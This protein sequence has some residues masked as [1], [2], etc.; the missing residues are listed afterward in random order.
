MKDKPVLDLIAAIKPIITEK[1][2]KFSG[3]NIVVFNVPVA[4][5]KNLMKRSIEYLYKDAKVL[6]ISS[7]II[8]GKVKRFRGTYGKRA[9]SKKMFVKLDKSIDITTGIK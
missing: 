4:T 2:L 7:T 8:K 6:N 3:D 5:S 1:S 9:D